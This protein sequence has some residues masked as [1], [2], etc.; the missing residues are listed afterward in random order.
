MSFFD[1]MKSKPLPAPQALVEQKRKTVGVAFGGGGLRGTAHVG[2]LKVLTEYG[3]PIDMVAGTSIGSAI[4]A[5]YASGYDWKMIKFLFD[6]FDIE[7]LLKVRPTRAGL[8]PADGY[9]ALIRTCTRRKQIEEM[10][11]PLKIVAVDLVSYKRI[12][13][14]RGDTAAAVRASSAIPGVFTPVTMGDMVLVDGF[15]LDNCPGDVVRE[16]GA[17]VVIAISL[18]APDH[19]PPQNIVDIVNRSLDVAATAFQDIDADILLEPISHHMGSLNVNAM[20][21]C[22]RLGEQCAKEHIEEILEIIKR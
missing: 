2:V 13:F 10:E 8:I 18:H 7:S 19:S 9:T 4:G 12:L 11:I 6:N 15:V 22:F 5:L 14:D 3:V 20:E 1:F 16:M 17:D 21:E